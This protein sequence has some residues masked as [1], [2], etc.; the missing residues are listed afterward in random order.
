MWAS[1]LLSP[2][3]HPKLSSLGTELYKS[4]RVNAEC[5]LVYIPSLVGGAYVW[6]AVLQKG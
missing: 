2:Y 6:A 1:T 5:T 4:P 3:L